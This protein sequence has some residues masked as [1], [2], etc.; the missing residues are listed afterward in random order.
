[1]WSNLG[2]PLRPSPED[3]R[4]F[5]RAVNTAAARTNLLRVL[6]LGVTPELHALSYPK[7]SVVQA[8][9]HTHLTLRARNVGGWIVPYRFTP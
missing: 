9:D 6:I 4:D 7:G 1:M 3:V 5:Q 2:P 8:A